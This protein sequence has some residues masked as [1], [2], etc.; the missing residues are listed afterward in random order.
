MGAVDGV[1]GDFLPRRRNEE[2]AAHSLGESLWIVEL[3]DLGDLPF[4]VLL[5]WVVP[6]HDD[7]V[8]L[9]HRVG[10]QASGSVDPFGI[11]DLAV[12]ALGVESPSME[13]AHDLAVLDVAT[14]AE[15]V[16]GLR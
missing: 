11:R 7:P 12:P 8:A 14:V 6:G 1:L 4:R 5:K 3:G 9:D 2:R 15:V 10:A 13:R 16:A